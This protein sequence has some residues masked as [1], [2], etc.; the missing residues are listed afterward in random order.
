MQIKTSLPFLVVLFAL[1]SAALASG[2]GSEMRSPGSFELPAAGGIAQG[3]KNLAT[4]QNPASL[5]YGDALEADVHGFEQDSDSSTWGAGGGVLFSSGT[6]GGAIQADHF[7]LGGADYLRYGV[8]YNFLGAHTTIGIAG[9]TLIN[10]GGGSSINV[11]VRVEPT[12]SLRIG[13]TYFDPNGYTGYFGVGVAYDVTPNI[14]I[15][16]D[17][18]YSGS[19]GAKSLAFAPGILIG[20]GTAAV[21]YSYGIASNTAAEDFN[22]FSQNSNAGVMLKLGKVTWALRYGIPVYTQWSTSFTFIL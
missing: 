8:G 22:V 14:T 2:Y 6:W 1:P 10:D 12:A 4:T 16:T 7:N 15:L 5:V 9:N 20:N 3:S 21:T 11:G 13:A 19:I 17:A 18:S